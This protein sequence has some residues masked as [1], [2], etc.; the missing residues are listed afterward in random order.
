MYRKF[1]AGILLG[2]VLIVLL[3]S[4]HFCFAKGREIQQPI[5]YVYPDQSVWTT[6]TDAKGI[7]KNPLLKLAEALFGKLEIK[8]TAKA[9]P[10]NRM[11]ER[12]K[13]GKS[14]FS[15]LVKA[16][17]LKESCLFSK[18]PIVS[19]E[20]RIYRTAGSPPVRDIA[21]LKGKK[22]IT[23][24]GYSYGA[25]G[26]YLK[27]KTNNILIFEALLHK[28]AFE[29]LA[30]GRAPYLLNYTGPSE[31][32]LSENPIPGVSSDVLK[33]LGVYFVLSKSYPDAQKM[34]NSFERALLSIDVGQWGLNKP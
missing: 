12:L 2:I 33:K 13:E 26:K 4:I 16:P 8:W 19:T 9:Y 22:L 21:D 24:R 10:A 31:E 29:M 28:H 5:A 34:M 32:I 1:Y 7:L 23:I 25:I 15:M 3:N 14:N 11:F 30:Q 18:V 6:K 20:L 17:Q 27:D